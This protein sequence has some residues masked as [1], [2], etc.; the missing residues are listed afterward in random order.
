MA[1]PWIPNQA[2]NDIVNKI[3][4]AELLKSLKLVCLVPPYKNIKKQ[5]ASVQALFKAFW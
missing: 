2:G 1:P 4:K 5:T 3:L